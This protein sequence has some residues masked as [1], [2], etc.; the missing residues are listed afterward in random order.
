M[1]TQSTISSV[2]GQEIPRTLEL[3]IQPLIH[4]GQV[5]INGNGKTVMDDRWIYVNTSAG[6]RVIN[7]WRARYCGKM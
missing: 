6:R 1:N 4:E 3:N 5:V 2:S 7:L